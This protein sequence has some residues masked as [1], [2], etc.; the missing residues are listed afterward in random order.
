M[1]PTPYD[2]AVRLRAYG[3]RNRWRPSHLERL[4]SA[5]IAD[6][7]RAL[8]EAASDIDAINPGLLGP[9]LADTRRRIERI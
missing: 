3:R 6:T 9:A 1:K 4:A 2:V 7:W 8:A 5:A